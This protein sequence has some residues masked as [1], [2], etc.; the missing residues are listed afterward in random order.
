MTPRQ[1]ALVIAGATA[2]TT[3]DHDAFDE[4]GNAEACSECVVVA[5]DSLVALQSDAVAE[6]EG[7]PVQYRVGETD[8][9]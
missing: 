8:R 9:T 4:S 5:R 2:L 6:L 1:R 3:C 7:R